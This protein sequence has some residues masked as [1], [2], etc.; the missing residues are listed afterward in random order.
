MKALALRQQTKAWTAFKATLGSCYPCPERMT[1]DIQESPLPESLQ[2][3]EDTV[4]EECLDPSK[5]DAL[6][7]AYAVLVLDN[8]R[9]ACPSRP[10]LPLTDSAAMP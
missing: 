3:R 2:S 6:Y 10:T 7:C 4:T 5:R 8:E 9:G 1:D